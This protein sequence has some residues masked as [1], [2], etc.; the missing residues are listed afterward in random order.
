MPTWIRLFLKHLPHD[1]AQMVALMRSTLEASALYRD[2]L[3]ALNA[4]LD[5]HVERGCYVYAALKS[6][7]AALMDLSHL[8]ALIATYGLIQGSPT[9][10]PTAMDL[11]ALSDAVREVSPRGVVGWLPEPDRQVQ[12]TLVRGALEQ[13][14]RGYEASFIGSADQ[15][16]LDGA[17]EHY[18][19]CAACYRQLAEQGRLRLMRPLEEHEITALAEE[20]RRYNDWSTVHSFALDLFGARVRKVVLSI[21][22]GDEGKFPFVEDMHGYDTEDH[23]LPYDLA[24]PFFQ[25]PL[26]HWTSRPFLEEI[27]EQVGGP[28]DPNDSVLW[29]QRRHL[30]VRDALRD[31]G[32]YRTRDLPIPASG[33]ITYDL[34]SPPP[35]TFPRVYASLASSAKTLGEGDPIPRR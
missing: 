33:E 2:A 8:A 20:Y 6:L 30:A 16:D 11:L 34:G 12:R 7:D 17:V 31:N 13:M 1:Y 32:I 10:L 23:P 9:D 26:G 3:R 5:R 15:V 4:S 29:E 35:I 21:G 19:M 24:Q 14:V 22:W 27:D 28:G 18:L 25:Q